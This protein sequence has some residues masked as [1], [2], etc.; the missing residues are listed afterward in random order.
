[1]S[2]M[3][4]WSRLMQISQSITLLR[5]PLLSLL[6]LAPLAA[7]SGGQP[8]PLPPRAYQPHLIDPGL[9]GG[10]FRY[11]SKGELTPDGRLLIGFRNPDIGSVNGLFRN[12]LVA[13]VVQTGRIQRSASGFLDRFFDPLTGTSPYG[14][15]FAFTAPGEASQKLFYYGSP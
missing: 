9:D 6:S 1:G 5:L 4:L 13:A 10:S 8:P 12:G 14:N 15:N 3:S 2:A 7:Q 11:F